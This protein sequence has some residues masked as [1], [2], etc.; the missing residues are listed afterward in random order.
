MTHS[1]W[2]AEQLLD[3]KA[4]QQA[5]EHMPCPRCGKDTMKP[6]LLTNA[7][8]ATQTCSFATSAAPRRPCSIS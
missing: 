5:G 1:D 6:D 3:L 7:L 2:I 4:R 8:A